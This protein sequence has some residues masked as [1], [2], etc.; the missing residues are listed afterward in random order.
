MKLK[1]EGSMFAQPISGSRAHLLPSSLSTSSVGRTE[2][3]S[4]PQV[5]QQQSSGN[6]NLPQKI[7]KIDQ[8]LEIKKLIEDTDERIENNESFLK[9]GKRRRATFLTSTVFNGFLVASGFLTILL[10]PALSAILLPP[11]GAILI[12]GILGSITAFTLI[13]YGSYQLLDTLT[14]ESWTEEEVNA[15]ANNIDILKKC[16]KDLEDSD[17]DFSRFLTRFKAPYKVNDLLK[18][19][20]LFRK[21]KKYQRNQNKYEQLHEIQDQKLLRLNDYRSYPQKNDLIEK[22]EKANQSYDSIILEKQEQIQD[23]QKQLDFIDSQK[24]ETEQMIMESTDSNTLESLQRRLEL[25]GKQIEFSHQDIE[26]IQEEIAG[27]EDKIHDNQS[28]IE[29]IQK[30]PLSKLRRRLERQ[31]ERNQITL[32][33]LKNENH[34]LK[35]KMDTLDRE[36]RNPDDSKKENTPDPI[37]P[38]LKEWLDM[39]TKKESRPFLVN[40]DQNNT[41]YSFGDH[42]SLLGAKESIK[43]QL[44][45]HGYSS[46]YRFLS[47]DDNSNYGITVDE[48]NYKTV[49]HY[50]HSQKARELKDD[51]GFYMILNAN[52]PSEVRQI[53]MERYQNYRHPNEDAIMKKAL[54]AKFVQTD[55]QSPTGDGVKLIKTAGKLLIGGHL[56]QE[57]FNDSTWGAV[58]THNYGMAM[59]ENRLGELLME[60]R[61]WLIMKNPTLKQVT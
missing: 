59:G 25:I 40:F 19:A 45:E 5:T 30:Y 33:E 50:F 61:D 21:E 29:T 57:H 32:D 31:V 44:A 47:N 55:G 12:G 3:L 43:T 54:F 10:I 7:T 15:L 53:A 8:S 18:Y 6:G 41:I 38:G 46:K 60:L 17:S 13:G 36:L 42:E 16:Q 48:V 39:P 2:R 23:L 37:H 35:A 11:V 1:I 52:T 34:V 14:A 28:E 26:A 9:E 51:E 27:I 20:S 24:K 4:V 58:F 56:R 49:E 22:I